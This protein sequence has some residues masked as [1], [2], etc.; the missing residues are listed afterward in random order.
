MRHQRV[1]H[2]KLGWFTGLGEPAGFATRVLRVWV[3]CRIC[4][5]AP[6]PYPSRVT[7]RFQ[8][9]NPPLLP[10]PSPSLAFSL[11]LSLPLLHTA[12]HCPSTAATPCHSQP[13]ATLD[14]ATS[15]LDDAA[16][17]LNDTT[18]PSTSRCYE[19]AKVDILFFSPLPIPLPIPLHLHLQGPS[20]THCGT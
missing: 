10:S 12:S 3:R 15:A 18:L 11:A 13:A 17:A 16:S 20:A 1:A 8:P 2:L 5:P 19:T 14:D 7:R 6:T 4:R 9:P